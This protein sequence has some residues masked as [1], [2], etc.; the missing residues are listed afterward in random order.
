MSAEPLAQRLRAAADAHDRAE[1]ADL[2][3][4]VGELVRLHDDASVAVLL[5]LMSALT[6]VPIAGA[7]TVLSFGLVVIAWAWV[8]GQDRVPLP[9]RL[10]G[11]TLNETWTRRCLHGL[12][13]VYEQA[14]RWLRPRWT[15]WSHGATRALWGAWIALMAAII[16]LPLP[17]GNVLPSVSLILLGLG[18]MARDG[19]ALLLSTLVGSAAVGYT[20]SLGHLALA[21]LAP[22]RGWLGV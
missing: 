4:S 1:A 10:D 11:L 16:F 22:V 2:R 6:V 3:L 14:T 5:M 12:A 9:R 17:L 15:V 13:W 19:I 20:V 7:G 8:R 21:A 18:W